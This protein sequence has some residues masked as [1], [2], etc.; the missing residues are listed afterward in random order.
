MS[1]EYKAQNV[2]STYSIIL[3]PT[4]V[5]LLQINA[6]AAGM[7]LNAATT[8]DGVTPIFATNGT[9]PINCTVQIKD[10][11][12]IIGALTN[13]ASSTLTSQPNNEDV[14]TLT[15]GGVADK[16]LTQ[17]QLNDMLVRIVA[18]WHDM[19]GANCPIKNIFIKFTV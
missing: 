19:I 16:F 1:S 15:G 13:T 14:N 11:T 5:G 7:V 18:E 2:N 12:N 6:D 9:T 10:T 17:A 3:K 4:G 8:V